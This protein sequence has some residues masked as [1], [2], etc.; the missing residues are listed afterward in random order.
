MFHIALFV[1]VSTILVGFSW[2]VLGNPKSHGFYRFFAFES[3]LGLM[4]LN[5]PYWFDEPT[6]LLHLIS[7]FLLI[8]SV[9]FVVQ[10]LI[11]FKRFGGNNE[12]QDT[13]ENFAFENTA[14][15]VE[16]GLY[17]FVRHPMYSSLLF[18]G[19]GAF[20]KNITPLNIALIATVTI[21]LI[22]VAKIEEREN[23]HF[24]GATYSDYMKRTK[25]FI[26]WLL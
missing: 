13:P 15:L 10:A 7:W 16:D 11:L 26:P 12:R 19:W 23:I 2:R 4:V 9:I 24:F 22:I 21:L 17:R 6:S 3:I 20:F 14:N 1:I 25:M 18:L 8:L 5:E